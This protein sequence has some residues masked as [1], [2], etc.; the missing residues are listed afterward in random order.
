MKIKG[1]DDTEDVQVNL[2]ETAD[3]ILGVEAELQEHFVGTVSLYFSQVTMDWT[4]SEGNPEGVLNRP[5]DRRGVQDLK[6]TFMTKGLFRAS[7]TNHMSVSSNEA[8]IHRL[9]RCLNGTAWPKGDDDFTVLK[10]QLARVDK[11]PHADET[12]YPEL[13]SMEKFVLQGGQH[14]FAALQ[15]L[16]ANEPDQIWWPCRIYAEPLSARAYTYL[17]E[18]AKT[19]QLALSDG[20]RFITLM[21]IRSAITKMKNTLNKLQKVDP[22]YADIKAKI[23]D[24]ESSFRLLK[25]HGNGKNTR[26]TSLLKRESLCAAISQGL[27]HGAL[28]RDFHFGAMGDILG[29]RITDV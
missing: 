20:E 25:S 3:D 16:Y 13:L 22:Q 24:L 15:E 23:D 19:T 10:S 27:Q 2:E 18:N 29:W 12:L 4:K 5:V 21:K 17:R 9:L 1:D 28:A 8:N 11:I 6:T 14:R 26:F 7:V